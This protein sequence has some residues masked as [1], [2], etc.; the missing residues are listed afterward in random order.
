MPPW[1]AELIK[2][3]LTVVLRELLTPHL[4]PPAGGPPKP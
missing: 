1:L 4:P 3:A 2:E